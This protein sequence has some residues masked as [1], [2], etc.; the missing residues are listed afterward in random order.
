MSFFNGKVYHLIFEDIHIYFTCKIYIYEAAGI[1]I[2]TNNAYEIL[3]WNKY[4]D[5]QR[6]VSHSSKSVDRCKIFYQRFTK[7]PEPILIIQKYIERYLS[8]YPSASFLRNYN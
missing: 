7:N 3:E 2:L 5:L 6:N 8:K 4:L 1:K